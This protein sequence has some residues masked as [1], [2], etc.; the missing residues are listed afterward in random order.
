MSAK[1]EN[2]VVAT[3]LGKISFDSILKKGILFMGFSRQE[4]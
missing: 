2:S 3:G 4:Y 1:L